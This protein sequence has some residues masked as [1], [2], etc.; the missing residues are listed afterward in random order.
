MSIPLGISEAITAGVV[1]LC[2]GALM[3]VFPFATP[4]TVQM[5]GVR[6]S[7]LLVRVG[8]VGLFG[9]GVFLLATSA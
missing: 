4:Q 9:Y 8:G 5:L 6:T 7:V 3:V 1:V 2:F